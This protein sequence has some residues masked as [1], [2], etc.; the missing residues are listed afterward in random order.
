MNKHGGGTL[1][2]KVDGTQKCVRI[3]AG[4]IDI[5]LKMDADKTFKVGDR[6]RQKN[7]HDVR[8][9]I[10]KIYMGDT[11]YSF[12]ETYAELDHGGPNK[13]Y[14]TTCFELDV[15]PEPPR[16]SIVIDTY[17]YAFQRRQWRGDDA[18]AQTGFTQGFSWADLLQ[19]NGKPLEV[20]YQP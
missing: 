18:W 17:G 19:Y 7:H 13:S 11:S 20:V 15:Q 4:A 9:T 1:R 16:G 2:Y 10:T 3:P 8:G 6:V 12:A 5:F 14:L